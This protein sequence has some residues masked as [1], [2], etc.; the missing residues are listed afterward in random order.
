MVFVLECEGDKKKGKKL[1]ENINFCLFFIVPVLELGDWASL[2]SASA[3]PVKL[4]DF[5]FVF[6]YGHS[7]I[8]MINN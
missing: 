1:G 7:C 2:A 3:L 5:V 8:T 6:V 4:L